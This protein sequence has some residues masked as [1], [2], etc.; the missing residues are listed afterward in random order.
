M[1]RK[2]KRVFLSHCF[3]PTF[4]L[5]LLPFQHV[6]FH[7]D[8]YTVFAP[9]LVQCRRTLPSCQGGTVTAYSCGCGPPV[10]CITIKALACL[11]VYANLSL[12]PPFPSISLLVFHF[13]LHFTLS[14]HLSP[15]SS[16]HPSRKHHAK[17]LL[18][19]L[20]F[21]MRQNMLRQGH[22]QITSAFVPAA[23]LPLP[24]WRS[25]LVRKDRGKIFGASHN[26]KDR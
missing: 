20:A 21:Y 1:N 11:P 19:C 2:R 15:F 4:S 16:N 26:Q 6:S 3:F 13:I 14:R 24:C 7:L 5:L 10:C 8:S 18:Y 9:Q 17:P 23:L 22:S 25:L 12:L